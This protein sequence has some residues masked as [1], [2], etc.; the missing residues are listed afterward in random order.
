MDKF[1]NEALEKTQHFRKKCKSGYCLVPVEMLDN[2]Y[3]SVPYCYSFSIKI[4]NSPLACIHKGLIDEFSIIYIEQLLKNHEI[5]FSNDVFCIFLEK[6]FI[7]ITSKSTYQADFSHFLKWLAFRRRSVAQ[8][9][10]SL[11]FSDL[12]KKNDIRK[13]LDI[14]RMIRRITYKKNKKKYERILIITANHYGNVGDDAITHAAFKILKEVFHQAKISI[15]N[16]PIDRNEIDKYDLLILGGGGIFYDSCIRNVINYT[17]LM[18]YAS[19]ANIPHISFGIGTQG[20]N[21]EIG[22]YIFRNA[23]NKSKLTVV[24]DP[25]DKEL[26]TSIGVK[27]PIEVSNDIVFSLAPNNIKSYKI[28]KSSKRKIGISLIAPRKA[29]NEPDSFKNSDS[30]K[31]YT[32]TIKSLIRLLTQDNYEIIYLCQSMDDIDMYEDLKK[33]YGGIIRTINYSDSINGYK[34]YEDLDLCITSRFHGLIFAAI[35]GVPIISIGTSA[36][37]TDRLISNS[38]KSIKKYHLSQ[39]EFSLDHLKLLLNSWKNNP[40][41]LIPSRTEIY[42][43]IKEA[44]QTKNHIKHFIC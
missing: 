34:F 16:C 25:K 41:M 15:D 38:L 10:P 17:S 4:Q 40:K 36:L 31:S 9:N 24:R 35:A 14:R 19:E 29:L 3:R 5:I 2:V 33:K 1:W 20:I 42:K 30:L 27:T 39:K 11:S 6:S 21:S 32:T 43:C 13:P 26:L 28:P 18:F 12:G 23:L 37:K 44:I 8:K 7:G 22:K